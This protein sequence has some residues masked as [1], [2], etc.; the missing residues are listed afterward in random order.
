MDKNDSVELAVVTPQVAHYWLNNNKYHVQRNVNRQRV[1]R[2]ESDMKHGEW[3]LAEAAIVLGVRPSGE[4]LLNG[5]HRLAAILSTG[6]PQRSIVLRLHFASEEDMD[7]AYANMDRG[8]IR[9]MR[10]GIAAMG[11]AEKVGVTAHTMK[12]AIGSLRLIGNGFARRG[13][14]GRAQIVLSNPSIVDQ[15]AYQWKEPIF[16]YQHATYGANHK[17]RDWFFNAPVMSVAL[18][19]LRYSP[20]C[21]MDF[22]R[23]ASENNGLQRG[24]PAHVL[25]DILSTTRVREKGE[26]WYSRAVATCWNAYADGRP[27]NS[28][29]VYAETPIT[30]R[31]SPFHGRSDIAAPD[32]LQ[33]LG[34]TVSTK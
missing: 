25:Y 6:I 10:Q 20:Q 2:Y 34:V 13:S 9:T 21:A 8:Y 1:A 24:E 27:L 31:K 32:P 15:I 3:G 29:R 28:A 23:V 16:A 11:T 18:V 14:S 26:E 19:T 17:A 4:H 5:Q 33:V 7:K 12:A 22:W 30:I